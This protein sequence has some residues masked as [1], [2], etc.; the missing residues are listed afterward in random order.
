[1]DHDLHIRANC[2]NYRHMAASYYYLQKKLRRLSSASLG[3]LHRQ[4]WFRS[5]QPDTLK[6]SIGYCSRKER[7]EDKNERFTKILIPHFSLLSILK[8]KLKALHVRHPNSACTLLFPLFASPPP[9]HPPPR[10]PRPPLAPLGFLPPVRPPAATSEESE[11]TLL[12]SGEPSQRT[13]KSCSSL[14]GVDVSGG[15][16]CTEAFVLQYN[17]GAH[18]HARTLTS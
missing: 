9:P 2:P 13:P 16:Q 6:S 14:A 1:V 11:R 4:V 15:T 3:Q 7:G 17:I 8:T 12:H 10:R 5:D 18:K